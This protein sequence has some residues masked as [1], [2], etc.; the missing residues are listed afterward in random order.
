MYDFCVD[1]YFT[2]KNLPTNKITSLF[3]QRLAGSPEDI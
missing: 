3:L 2:M 1:L